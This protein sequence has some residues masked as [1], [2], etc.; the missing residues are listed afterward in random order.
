MLLGSL[1]LTHSAFFSPNQCEFNTC[2]ISDIPFDEARENSKSQFFKFSL[3]RQA[4][5]FVV[6]TALVN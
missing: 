5:K 6:I 3:F 4:L 2:P 1:K